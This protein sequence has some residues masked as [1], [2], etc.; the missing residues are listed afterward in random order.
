[1]LTTLTVNNFTLVESLEVDFSAGMTALTGETGAGKSLVLDALSMALGDRADTDRIRQ[2]RE[3]AEVT[4][5]FDISS[6]PA[7]LDW[8]EQNDF[9][10]E[11]NEC[12][13]RR[14]LTREGRSRGYI[15]GQPATMQQLRELGDML[16]DIHSQHEH[17]SLL[18]RDSHRLILDDF[19]GC[20]DMAATVRDTQRQWAQ[21]NGKLQRLAE[22]SEETQALKSLLE[23]QIE[24]FSQLALEEGELEQLEQRQQL[25]ANAESILRDSHTLLELCREGET[26]NLQDG[27]NRAVQLLHAMPN[28]P[29]AL[30]E[31][32]KLLNSALIEVE[33]AGREVQHHLDSFEMDPE[34]LQHIE[35]RL[36]AIYQLARKHRINPEQLPEKQAELEAEL[37]ELT[38]GEDSLDALQ[39]QVDELMSHYRQQAGELSRK[40][41]AAAKQLS[42][43]IERQ[44]E[45]LSMKGARF[46]VELQA[47]DAQKPSPQGLETVEFLIATNPGA[48]PRPLGKIAS[49]GELSRISLAIQVIA[50]RHSSIPTL[51]FD[52]V[53]VGIGGATADV[54]GRLLR[55][56][57]D[58]GQVICVTHQPQVAAWAHHQ[59]RVSKQT[60]QHEAHSDIQH[61]HEPERVNEIARML[62]GS[63]ITDTTLDH[64]RELLAIAG[65]TN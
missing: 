1:M 58:R 49:G 10:V 18:R 16:V 13:L 62:G 12:L 7:A 39:Q 42:G 3:R 8:L 28:T 24:E 48:P 52:E 36:S 50:A 54:V 56:L 53:D 6:T 11:D 55:E 41:S 57:G 38:G 22:A 43:Q 35:E 20:A 60:G 5:T 63:T 51:V 33:E 17:Q 15:N 25:L 21:Q 64:A 40:R 61:L 59:L 4:A 46:V 26:F 9:S 47:N 29:P 27:L 23:F 65:D 19:A 45:A 32:E 30:Q 2:R 31:V 14:G 44:F 34:E 37:S